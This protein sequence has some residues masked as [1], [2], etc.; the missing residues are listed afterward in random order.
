MKKK[1]KPVREVTYYEH[2]GK[3]M[4]FPK[5]EFN[6]KDEESTAAKAAPRRAGFCLFDV[7]CQISCLTKS[8]D[9]RTF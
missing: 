3:A 2:T 9:V 8:D 1:K 4:S 7:T 5:Y 6:F